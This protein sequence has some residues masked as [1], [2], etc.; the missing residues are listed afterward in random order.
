MYERIYMYMYMY[1][2]MYTMMVMTTMTI[3][4]VAMMAMM[5]TTTKMNFHSMLTH[6]L[7]NLKQSQP[8][9][10]MHGAT[11]RGRAPESNRRLC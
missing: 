7:V 11:G 8:I 4:M 10:D 1:M 9:I 5:A 6:L 2:C 3:V